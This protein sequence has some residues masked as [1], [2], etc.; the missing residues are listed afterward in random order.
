[1]VP[2]RGA[3]AFGRQFRES[4]GRRC[5]PCH[6]CHHRPRRGRAAVLRPVRGPCLHVDAAAWSGPA[7]AERAAGAAA[8]G[9]ILACEAE[10]IVL[11]AFFLVAED[12][13]SP[14]DF[15]EVLL[16]LLVAGV[17]V[18]VVFARQLA[19]GRLELCLGGI[20]LYPED[21]VVIARHGW[22][23]VGR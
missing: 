14:L 7:P 1:P 16:G 8:E 17:A 21:F 2:R 13:V 15:L 19:V 23:D 4:P 22:L 10:A 5:R 3:V 20:P 11:G 18:G 12:V 6:P 9:T